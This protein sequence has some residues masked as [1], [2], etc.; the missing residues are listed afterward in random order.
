MSQKSNLKKC[1]IFLISVIILVLSDQITKIIAVNSLSEGVFVIIPD[2]LKLDL[3]YNSGAAFGMLKDSRILFCIITII[4]VSFITLLYF[5]SPDEKRFNIIKIDFIVLVSG[6][7]GNFIDRITSGVVTDFISFKFGSYYFP[8]F[9]VADIYVTVSGI[10]L[11]Y[12]VIFHYKEKD[13]S[14]LL[15]IRSSK[16]ESDDDMDKESINDDNNV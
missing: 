2:F 6:A 3:L 10:L 9:N 5:R 11:F 12:L 14:M 4:L 13:L 1:L 7:I 8:T 15:N 16:K